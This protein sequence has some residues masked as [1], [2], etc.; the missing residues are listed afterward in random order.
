MDS[1]LSVL[2][3]TGSGEIHPTDIINVLPQ[4]TLG[5]LQVSSGNT[6]SFAHDSI[7]EYL[8]SPLSQGS[9]FSLYDESSVHAH[10][11]A[12]CVSYLAHNIPKQPL[13]AL[14]PH[15]SP[16][17]PPSSG[18]SQRTSASG[19]SGYKSLS[20]SNGDIISHTP[21]Q[22]SISS[23]PFDT[24]LPFLRYASLCWPI[25][26]SRALST[27]LPHH[28][29]PT[30]ISYLPAL[31]AFLSC[32]LAVTVWVEA[33]FRYN[34]PPTLTRLVG[35]LSDL[36]GEFPPGTVEGRELR[37]VASNIKVLS[38]G[39]LHLK[40]ECE[41]ELRANAS[42]VWQMREAGSEAYW[43]VWEEIADESANMGR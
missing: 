19:D 23:I 16:A 24:H 37:F 26:L 41:G 4:L 33:S 25:H 21:A 8:Q 12:R 6:I 3:T 43:P 39:L 38:E 5:L 13:A 28:A 17:I 27:P 14:Q 18:A 31:S 9:E 29:S 36:K 11:T 42:L 15:T 1:A 22:T 34:L 32:R 40:R 10:L 30:A 20:S 7:R 2:D 35:P